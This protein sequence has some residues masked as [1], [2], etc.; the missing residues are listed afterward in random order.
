MIG[1]IDI[2]TGTNIHEQSRSDLCKLR[3]GS[4]LVN[5][6]RAFNRA[7]GAQGSVMYNSGK[8]LNLSFCMTI[9]YTPSELCLHPKGAL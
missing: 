3:F 2:Y 5:E 6:L 8:L 4:K 9:S 1:M 7:T